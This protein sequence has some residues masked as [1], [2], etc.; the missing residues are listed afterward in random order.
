MLSV[1][2]VV[3]RAIEVTFRFLTSF[4]VDAVSF[5][6]SVLDPATCISVADDVT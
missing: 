5:L 3:I 1:G 2:I 4:M 6:T